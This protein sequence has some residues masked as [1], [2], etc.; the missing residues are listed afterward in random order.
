M[1]KRWILGAPDPEQNKAEHELHEAVEENRR[2]TMAANTQ[3]FDNIQHSQSTV[4]VV[5]TML[6]RMEQRRNASPR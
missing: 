6:E 4:Q 2:V 3:V 5:Q 1:I